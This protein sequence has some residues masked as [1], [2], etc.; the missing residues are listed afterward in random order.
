MY[1]TNQLPQATTVVINEDRSSETLFR[2]TS[3]KVKASKSKGQHNNVLSSNENVKNINS[4]KIKN[5]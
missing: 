4:V 5:K 2:R 3:K 1:S